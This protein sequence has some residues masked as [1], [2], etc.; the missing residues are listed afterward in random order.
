MAYTSQSSSDSS[1]DDLHFE[2]RLIRSSK[3][4]RYIDENRYSFD[5]SSDPFGGNSSEE[6]YAPPPKKRGKNQIAQKKNKTQ[7][8]HDV[9]IP[10][11][12]HMP[13]LPSAS[14]TTDFNKQF[15]DLS[16]KITKG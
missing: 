5:E 1:S 3:P 6:I 16:A 14:H 8:S 12:S 9:A 7:Q 11:T 13:D 4:K 15:A 10:S 2:R